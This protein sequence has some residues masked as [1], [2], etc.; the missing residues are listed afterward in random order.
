MI[1][2][3]EYEYAEQAIKERSLG[4]K[5]SETLTRVAKYHLYNGLTKSEVRKRLEEF[6]RMC[7]PTAALPKW[8]KAIDYA[9]SRAVKFELV[10][11]DSINITKK[12]IEVINNIEGRPCKRLAFTLLCL[13]K[14]W[15]AVN[16]SA[17]YWVGNKDTEIMKL[18]NIT[19]SLRKQSK[20]FSDMRDAGL[21]QFAKR[22][23]SNAVKVC[24]VNNDGD[25]AMKIDNFRDLGNQY[26]MYIGEPYFMCKSC[27]R[28]MKQTHTEARGR[29]NCYC[30][31]C[32]AKAKIKQSVESVMRSRCKAKETTE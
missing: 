16:P 12:E 27:G 6:I 23:D 10:D 21:L 5:P 31:D 18:A 30:P 8:D 29:K 11:I 19:T 24:F 17:D 1:V 32:A 25:I 20:M 7:D 9:I 26:L 15:Q 3:N 2:L 28:V 13:A 14:Y 4:N 22:V